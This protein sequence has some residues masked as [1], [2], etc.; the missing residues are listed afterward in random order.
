[1]KRTTV[2][3][4]EQT[5]RRLRREAHRLGVSSATLVRE[6]VSR[7]LDAPHGAAGLPPIAGKF[8]SG[9]T[10]TAERVDALLWRD[11]HA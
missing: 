1:M 2:F 4:D 9:A 7:Y 6:A 8:A 10:D 11:P 5:I 3:L